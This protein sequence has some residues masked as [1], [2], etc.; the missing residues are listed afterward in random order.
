MM[1]VYKSSR[2]TLL[3][4][5]CLISSFAV[6]AQDKVVSGTV[7]DETG[8]PIPGVS[9]LVKGTTTGTLTDANG[10]FRISA[11]DTDVLSFTFV[12]YSATEIS[13]GSQTNIEASLK[14]DVTNL[15]EVVVTGYSVDKRRELTGAVSSV[16]AKDLVFAPTGNVEQMLQGRVPG[17]TV[18]TN[19]QPGTTSQVRVRGFGAFG[20]NQPLYI[21]DG[22]PTG[23]ISFLNPDDIETTTVLK[24][25]ASA[26]IYGARAASGVI[27]YTT[28]RGKRNQKLNVTYDGMYGFT[29]PGK[30]IDMMNPSDFADWTFNAIK[31]TAVQNGADPIAALAT[32]NHPQFGK[33]P[34]PVIPDYLS[35]GGTPG[36]TGTVDLAAE[37]LK[38]N[39]DPRQGSIY[40]VIAANKSGTDWFKEITHNAPVYRQTL[41][42]SGGG[43]SHRFYVGLSAQDQKGI[44]INNSL[45]RYALRVNSEFDIL[46]NLR[47]G[48]NIQ[49]T[50]RQAL[51]L[52]GSSG[53][54]GIAADEN[55]IL[56]AFRMPSIIPVHDVFGGYAGTAAK[57]FNNPRNPVAS[58]EG[59][60]NDRAFSGGVYGNIYAELDPIPGLTLRT[61]IGGNYQDVFGRNY[62]RWQY[63][64]SENN[65]AFGFSQFQ[66]YSLAW[67]VTNTANYKLKFGEHN[68]EVLAGQEALNTGAGWNSSQSGINP[69][70]WDPNYIDITKLASTNQPQSSQT[71]GVNFS[72]YFGNVKYSFKEKYIVGLVIRRDGSSRFGKN[73][74]YGVFPAASA[75]WRISSEPFMQSVSFVNDLKIRGGYGAM[76]NSNNVNPLNQYS[77]YGGDVGNSSYDITGSNSKATTGFYRTRIGNDNA[78]WETSITKNIGIDGLFFG[79]KL[80]VVVD[81][82]QKDTKD[83][84]YQLPITATAGPGAASPSVNIA[85]ML[86]KGIDLAITTKGNFTGDLKYEATFTGSWLK[87]EITSIAPGQTYLT[88]INPGF[89]GLNPIRN[90][91]NYPISSFYGYIVEGLFQDAGD[92]SN[93]AQQNGAAPGRLKYKD[94]NGD[95]KIDDNDRTFMGSPVPKFTG[96]FN[97]ILRWKGIDLTAYM[98][99]SLGGKIFNA[100]RWFTDFYPSF[101]GAAIATRV[102]DSWTPTNT[103]A[104]IP[105]F[106][107]ASNFSTNQIANS[108]YVE[109]GNYLRLQ[110]VTLGYTFPAAMVDKWKMTKLRFYAAANNL[111]TITK[112]KGLDPGVGG[113]ADTNFG[114]DVGNYPLTKQYTLGLNLG[115]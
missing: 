40:Q 17:V 6:L 38:Y 81:F 19:G 56:S 2:R 30:G 90:Q 10:Q 106:E 87:N 78:K 46:K 100:S 54:Q 98:Y 107:S 55:D 26:S 11:K 71:K 31:N 64:N 58:R 45:K 104:T 20:G 113:S 32:F 29:S 89:R 12:G 74:R 23:D 110:N 13:V 105:I 52:S 28:K 84:L 97:F 93:H 72:S 24:D 39:V 88:T 63:E 25:A 14:P 99:T 70:S 8:S 91:L 21:V 69:F 67:T 115:F 77:L 101:Q 68:I 42:F 49:V 108:Y 112:Y 44:L 102:K 85:R 33:G 35:V 5:L 86:N 79:G 53:G 75:A 43:E 15:E 83:L 7:K 3:F 62:S 103:G 34:T 16:K 109:N 94:V 60:A 114:I 73:N 36:V 9:V 47:V 41:G 61:S 37:K 76:G 22:V 82:W 95:G 4:L 66:S 27:V 111:F 57:G 65:S 1:K 96:G 48:E 92:V 51:G 50:Y 59:Q 80:D 18:I